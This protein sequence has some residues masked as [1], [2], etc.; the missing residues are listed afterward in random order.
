[1][2][3]IPK[4]KQTQDALLFGEKHKGDTEIINALKIKRAKAV[5]EFDDLL[6]ILKHDGGTDEQKNKLHLLA[7]EG[8]LYRE[9]Y[10]SAEGAIRY[11][12]N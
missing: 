10:E 6:R 8:Q 7:L 11:V 9:A 2:E 1:M 12:H 4:F 3:S 5:I